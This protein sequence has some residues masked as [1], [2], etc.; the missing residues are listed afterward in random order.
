M[1]AIRELVMLTTRPSQPHLVLHYPPPGMLR[2]LQLCW[3]EARSRFSVGAAR[4]E[5]NGAGDPDLA[6]TR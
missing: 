6:R 5:R 2:L 4:P 3:P 1:A